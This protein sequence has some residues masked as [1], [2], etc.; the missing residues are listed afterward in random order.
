MVTSVSELSSREAVVWRNTHAKNS[1][2]LIYDLLAK[3][4][5]ELLAD[6][7]MKANVLQDIRSLRTTTDKIIDQDD[8]KI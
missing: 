4:V 3:R 2:R 1:L 8:I 5:D 6:S 7:L